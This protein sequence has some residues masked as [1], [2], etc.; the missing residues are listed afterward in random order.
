MTN[1]SSPVSMIEHGVDG[2]DA[3]A[4]W[5]TVDVAST[6][7]LTMPSGTSAAPHHFVEVRVK[8]TSETVNGWTAPSNTA[9][10]F[11][12]FTLA[13]DASIAAPGTAPSS[14]ALLFGD[15]ITEGVRTV[16]QPATNDTDRNSAAMG[17]AYRRRAR[18]A[19]ERSVF[20]GV[21]DGRDQKRRSPSPAH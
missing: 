14:R 13:S 8:S 15:S 4:P 2:F 21:S 20:A 7:A 18:L 1:N 3:G 17:W 10:A 6:V 11:T 16:D 19:A 5:T 9:V 12:G